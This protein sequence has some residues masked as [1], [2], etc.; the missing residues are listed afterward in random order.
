MKK[1]HGVAIAL[2][3][4]LMVSLVFAQ[5]A[6]EEMTYGAG[7]IYSTPNGDLVITG[8]TVSMPVTQAKTTAGQAKTAPA[9]TAA[10]AHKTATHTAA[11][12]RAHTSAAATQAANQ[13]VLKK[14]EPQLKNVTTTTTDVYDVDVKNHRGE[15]NYGVVQQTVTKD[16]KSNTSGVI[17]SAYAPSKAA[18]ANALHRELSVAAGESMLYNRDFSGERYGT[19]GF[20]AD[21]SMLWDASNYLAVGVDYMMLHP[22]AKTHGTAGGDERHY[23]GMYAHAI[24][25]AGKLTLN[26]WNSFKIYSPM[27]IGMMN[28]R[29]K[30]EG[31]TSASEDHWGAAMYI[32]LGM[33]YDLTESLFAG[34]EYRYAF[35][36]ISDKHLTPNHRDRDLQFH[37][38]ML[39]MGMRF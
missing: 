14:G 23:H 11:Q 7:N 18:C 35:A 15:T 3:L 20:A 13:A 19:N 25:L 8:E 33:Q 5:P 17:Y 39:R 27:G 22:R 37:N 36:W 4:L 2:I 10:K 28:A 6:S 30:T 29:M 24:S 34:L 21:V 38:I 9:K 12:Q 1:I 26:P 16:G 32:G 31:I